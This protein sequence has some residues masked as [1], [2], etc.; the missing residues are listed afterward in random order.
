MELSSRLIPRKFVETAC[1]DGG[2]AGIS[3]AK[4]KVVH[5]WRSPTTLLIVA[6]AGIGMEGR[7]EMS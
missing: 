7:R 3:M 2:D 4:M 6:R 5:R 1:V